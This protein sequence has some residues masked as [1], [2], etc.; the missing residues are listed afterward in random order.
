[1]E[2]SGRGVVDTYT[3]FHRAYV[4]AFAAEVPY[5]LA[6]VRLEESPY[7]HTRLVRID[8]G[9]VTTGLRAVVPA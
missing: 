3:V 9:A 6:V 8:P 4:E 5:T 1:M 7:F 2:A